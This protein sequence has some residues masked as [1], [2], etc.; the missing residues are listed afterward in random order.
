MIQSTPITCN[1]KYV[2]N[3]RQTRRV[4]DNSH[5]H[6]LQVDIERDRSVT[7]LKPTCYTVISYLKNTEEKLGI[8]K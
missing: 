3:Y 7:G 8:V 6:S 4:S 2:I 5:H 1:A